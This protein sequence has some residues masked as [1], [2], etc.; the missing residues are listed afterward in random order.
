MHFLHLISKPLI[1]FFAFTL[2]SVCSFAKLSDR[3][4]NIAGII[5]KPS[6][7]THPS[8]ATVFVYLHGTTRP[9]IKENCSARRNAPP[10]VIMRLGKLPHSFI[11]FICSQKIDDVFL[12]G[13]YIFK[14]V[15]ELGQHLNALIKAGVS[16]QNIFLSGHSAGAWTALMASYQWRDYYNGSILFAPACCGPRYE[17]SLYPVWREQIRPLQIMT[18]LQAQEIDALVFSYEDDSFNRPADLDFLRQNYPETIKMISYSCEADH[19]T[20]MKDCQ[21]QTTYE[22]II[23]YIKQKKLIF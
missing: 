23:D 20:H 16:P 21:E 22:H 4:P 2:L 11:Y 1:I 10:P 5:E 14:R 8:K 6:E 12:G 7:I 19:Q 9:Q 13:S 18:M 15:E 3:P 17:V